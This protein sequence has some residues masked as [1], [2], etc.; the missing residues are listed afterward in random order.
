[1]YHEKLG[2]FT[3][4]SNDVVVFRGSSNETFR[5]WDLFGNFESF[6]VFCSWLNSDENNRTLIHQKHF[7]RLWQ[8]DLQGLDV[9][10][11]SKKAIEDLKRVAKPSL[12]DLIEEIQSKQTLKR[13]PFAF[14]LETI[15]NWKLNGRHGI[16][17]HA[18]GSGKTFTAVCIIKEH[19]ELGNPAIVVVP[20]LLLLK[21]WEDEISKEIPD[22]KMLLVSGESRIWKR[23][24]VLESYTSPRTTL[25]KRI[26][27]VTMQTARKAEFCT[28][29]RKGDH[30]LMVCDEVHRLGSTENKSTGLFTLL[31]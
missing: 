4:D 7:E 20:S 9:I 31:M 5:A 3:D 19:V 29:V 13:K 2:I 16:V 17:A 24:G 1:M 21:Q 25:G 22:A 10:P 26:I 15:N 23:N 12:S 6:D 28:S 18:T 11:L 14:Q 27:I 8:N 30:L